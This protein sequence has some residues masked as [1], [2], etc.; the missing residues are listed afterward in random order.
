MPV[1]ASCG[2]A[3]SSANASDRL[4]VGLGKS[5]E[6]SVDR[7]SLML[8]RA[9]HFAHSHSLVLSAALLGIFHMAAR[10]AHACSLM[11]NQPHTLDPQAQASDSTPPGVPTVS[12]ESIHRGK[13]PESSGCSQSASSCDDIGTVS[14]LVSATDDQTS[15][16]SIGYR[17]ELASGTLPSGLTLPSDAV[18]AIGGRLFLIWQDGNTDQQEALS[19]S[20]S[21]R[22]V[23]LAGNVGQPAT[24]QI[25]DPGS[26]SGC[27]VAAR[28]LTLGWPTAIAIL[29]GAF[30]FRRRRR[31]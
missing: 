7:G 17:I 4:V 1:T 24:I 13:G 25:S 3:T 22:A 15:A 5:R 27:T 18:R 19:F 2:K 11:A 14:L 21:I 28:G 31:S 16:E 29:A 9:P 23:D 26:G 6:R 20:L 8:H 12:V 30:L 10:P